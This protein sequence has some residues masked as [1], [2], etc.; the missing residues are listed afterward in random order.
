MHGCLDNFRQTIWS[1][2]NIASTG[3]TTGKFIGGD[4]QITG[5][6]T[7][8]TKNTFS[9]PEVVIDGILT[10]KNGARL[11]IRNGLKVKFCKGSKILVEN[12]GGL[13][14]IEGAIVQALASDWI[15]IQ[16]YG[17]TAIYN[18]SSIED[19][20]IGIEVFSGASANIASSFF[21]DNKISI[22]YNPGSL[23]S[24]VNESK[25]TNDNASITA[26][27]DCF[28]QM[29]RTDEKYITGCTFTGPSGGGMTVG[30]KATS[31]FFSVDKSTYL[32]LKSEFH[33][34]FYGIYCATSA[35]NQPFK[36]RNSLFKECQHGIFVDNVHFSKTTYTE[37][38]FNNAMGP[39]STGA[40]FNN[41]VLQ[42]W[43]E[44]NT[45]K[46]ANEEYSSAGILWN[47]T[48]FGAKDVYR[49]KA[50]RRSTMI[51]TENNGISTSGVNFT[52]NDF[53]TQS[54]AI[55][56]ESTGTFRTM[57]G[58][59]VNPN[60]PDVSPTRNKYH[61]NI[62]TNIMNW[63]LPI[64]YVHYNVPLET[65]T[66]DGAVNLLPR[67]S[68]MGAA[69]PTLEYEDDVTLSNCCSPV[70]RPCCGIDS[71]IEALY[72]DFE[73]AKTEISNL[74]VAIDNSNNS[75]L[76]S[77]LQSQ[78]DIWKAKYEALKNAIIHYYYFTNRNQEEDMNPEIR[79]APQI[80]GKDLLYFIEDFD[81]IESY[82][83]KMKEKCMTTSGIV[84]SSLN[85]DFTPYSISLSNDYI[86]TIAFSQV[87]EIAKKGE[88]ENINLDD[89]ATIQSI[90]QS[91]ENTI[92]R[93]WARAIMTSKY[94]TVYPPDQIINNAIPE[95]TMNRNSISN[96]SL[97]YPNPSNNL[98]NL[99]L[100]RY[101]SLIKGGK[102]IIFDI[103]DLRG[104]VVITQNIINPF[105][106]LSIDK[107][108]SGVYL[109]KL[110]ISDKTHEEG[111]LIKIE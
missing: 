93:S 83:W 47:K 96:K 109:Y 100:S 71:K 65:P 57:Q 9:S 14:I 43:L 70:V 82:M 18:N 55:R 31:S 19:A 39:F 88:I 33:N 29:D 2:S 66:T 53:Y 85:L 11:F 20:D 77:E 23:K 4:I 54:N 38:E 108:N 68:L 95:E 72:T 97:L 107:L 15:G 32:G 37:F 24:T 73:G 94:G 48:G 104:N 40:Y 25:F 12:G 75:N 17:T 5:S 89:M 10:I 61:V 80:Y 26:G 84:R 92:G 69:C 45:F 36:L 60:S 98:V 76:Q 106:T 49:N 87:F 101:S 74:K 3:G 44:A 6:L 27:F 8:W 51:G 79:T 110:K 105:T 86:N 13:F 22:K 34:L 1:S 46:N 64:F 90:A 7:N 58:Q 111:K 91:T 78:L 30:I 28:I 52:C 81:N 62:A 16:N 35:Q 59:R 42:T 50:Y 63:G 56:L 41:S 21:K 102:D 103:Y 99:D 67:N